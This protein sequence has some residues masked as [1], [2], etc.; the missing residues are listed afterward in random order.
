MVCIRYVQLQILGSAA[1]FFHSID[2]FLL[3]LAISKST[4]LGPRPWHLRLDLDGDW[5]LWMQAI[6]AR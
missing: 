1:I 4:R 3:F 2:A 6:G 5:F